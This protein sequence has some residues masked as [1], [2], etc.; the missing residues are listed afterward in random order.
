MNS[1]IKENDLRTALELVLLF[2]S[3]SSWDNAKMQK[4]RNGIKTI[5]GDAPMEGSDVTTKNLCNAVR[6]V[7][8]K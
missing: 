7:L 4:W 6:A 2:H 3:G 5:L 1:G 8:A